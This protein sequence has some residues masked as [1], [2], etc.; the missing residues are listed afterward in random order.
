MLAISSAENQGAD[1]MLKTKKIDKS[2]NDRVARNDKHVRIRS[3]LKA[4]NGNIHDALG[5]QPI[6]GILGLG[7]PQ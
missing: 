5:Y 2:E 7:W 1:E 4:G 6:D 3:G